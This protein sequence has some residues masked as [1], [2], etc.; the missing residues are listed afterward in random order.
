MALNLIRVDHATGKAIV[1]VPIQPRSSIDLIKDVRKLK[2][3]QSEESAI[4]SEAG[5]H[6]TK[7]DSTLGSGGQTTL[8]T[9]DE[10]HLRTGE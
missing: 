7:L 4:K 8:L 6:R 1:E 2:H 5:L 3:N 10:I 9:V